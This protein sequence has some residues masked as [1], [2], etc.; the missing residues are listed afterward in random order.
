M[1][2]DYS[3]ASRMIPSER[4]G[5]TLDYCVASDGNRNAGG[6]PRDRAQGRGR[7]WLTSGAAAAT[8]PEVQG[9]GEAM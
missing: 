7:W 2:D 3:G 9:T 4:L 6:E 5:D 1:P 8:G